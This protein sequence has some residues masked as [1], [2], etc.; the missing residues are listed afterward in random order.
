VVVV[1]GDDEPGVLGLAGIGVGELNPL[2]R[3]APDV[4][5][6]DSVEGAGVPV[7]VGDGVPVVAGALPFK[8]GAAPVPPFGP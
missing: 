3:P 7:V 1:L 8:G 4:L 5:G 2:P 6:A